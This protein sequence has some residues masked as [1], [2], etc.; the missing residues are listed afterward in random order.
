M[1]AREK[2][3]RKPRQVELQIAGSEDMADDSQFLTA[4]ARGLTVLET[5]VKAGA[6][7]GTGEI[8]KETGLSLPTVSRMAYTLY[9]LGYLQYISRERL[10]VPG[11]RSA[12]L[13]ALISMRINLRT[14]A[15]PLMEKLTR[16]TDCSVGI[17]TLVDNQMRY[18]DAFEAES[19][20]G[21]RLDVGMQLPVLNTAI[22]RAYLAGVSAETCDE[23]CE[24]LRPREEAEWN[25]LRARIK[26]SLRHY[27]DHGYCISIGEWHKQIN[28]VAAPISDPSTRGVYVVVAGAPAYSLPKERLREEIGPRL[29]ALVADVKK[30]V[31]SG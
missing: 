31:G 9:Q 24:K 6:P 25:D 17:G 12:L 4:L 30:A 29:L 15:R 28:S 20:I 1:T 21:L 27:R 2:S 22:G 26:S 3:R 11:P 18:L 5:C 7:I 10:Y 23:I 16:E 13:S 14:V 19:I 8:T